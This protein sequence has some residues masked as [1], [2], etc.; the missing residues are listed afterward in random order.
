RHVFTRP[1]DTISRGGPPMNARLART[2][3]TAATMTVALMCAGASAQEAAPAAGSLG[4]LPIRD[5]T[6]FKDGHAF[7]LRE[8]EM[9]VDAAGNVVI[10]DLPQ[11][12][13]GTFWPYAVDAKL[14]GVVAGQRRVSVERTA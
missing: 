7:V 4:A 6:I 9:P 10:D 5:V 12:V 14:A 11:P 2:T 13:L 3:M 8:G 1:R